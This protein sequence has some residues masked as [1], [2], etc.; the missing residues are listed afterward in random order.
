MVTG[1]P[2][3]TARST[4]ADQRLALG[5]GQRDAI[6]VLGDHR[7][8]NLDLAAVVGLLSG[9]V[10]EDLD[11]ELAARLQGA[12]VRGDPELVRGALG[13]DGD[14][15]AAPCA[16]RRWRRGRWQDSARAR[17]LRT[18]AAVDQDIGPGNETGRLR[19]QVDGQ[20]SRLRRPYP[21]GRARS[22]RRTVWLISGLVVRGRFISV[23]KGPGLIPTTVMPSS[24][25]SSASARVNPRSPALLA[26]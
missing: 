4:G 21:T 23:A 20:L 1:I 16:G 11:V 8:D 2:S 14:A 9:A 12:F 22:S 25:S 10:P 18:P 7:V 26:E 24:A 17:L 13:N 15:P 6:D 3:A 19:G 5:G